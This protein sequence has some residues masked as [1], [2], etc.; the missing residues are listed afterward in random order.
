MKKYIF[1]WLLLWTCQ[2]SYGQSIHSL[3]NEFSN[4]KN[5]EYV[6][7]SPFLMKLGAFFAGNDQEN[8]IVRH[9]RSIRVLDLEACSSHVKSRFQKKAA[10]LHLD[11]YEE[12]MRINNHGEKVRLLV[13]NQRKAIRELLILCTGD[14]DC[15][16]VH[17]NGKFT[18]KDIDQLVDSETHKPHGRR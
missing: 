18:S 8:Q 1:V 14:Q 16:L 17:I 9:I 5:A 10:R 3:F 15:T 13:K 11:G 2:L 4:E 7:V 12:W 6:N